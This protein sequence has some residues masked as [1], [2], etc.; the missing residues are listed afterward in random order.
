MH[1]LETI[2]K[3]NK[4]KAEKAR[5]KEYAKKLTLGSKV[6]I[7]FNLINSKISSFYNSLSDGY[8]GYTK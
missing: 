7:L 4:E 5:K 6:M 1:C 2:K 3:L 8:D